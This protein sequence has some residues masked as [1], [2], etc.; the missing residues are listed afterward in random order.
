MGNTNQ[1]EI[2]VE[3]L[4]DILENFDPKAKV[5]NGN[6]ETIRIFPGRETG[7]GSREVIMIC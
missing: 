3:M 7:E 6:E 4:I 1:K 2:T 5:L